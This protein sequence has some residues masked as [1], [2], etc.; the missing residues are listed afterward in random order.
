MRAVLREWSVLAFIALAALAVSLSGVT[1]QERGG[2]G[3]APQQGAG[4]GRTGKT[5]PF[6]GTWILN[7]S[8]STYEN[9]PP[10]ARR[11]PSIRTIDVEGDGY[12]TETHRNKTGGGREGFFHWHGIPGGA[13]EI[14]E[15]GRNSGDAPG[16]KLTIKVNNDHQWA[17]TFRNQQN[18][19]VISDTWTV[20]PDNKTLTIDRHSIGAD[21]KP[22]NHAVEVFDNEGWAM[23]RPASQ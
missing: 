13:A 9:V 21:G 14:V 6:V 7:V 22:I 1:A 23:P 11:N 17:V 12:F 8:K 18:Q 2:R 10:E 20:S 16:N 15:Y 3:A 19:I 4:R 5:S